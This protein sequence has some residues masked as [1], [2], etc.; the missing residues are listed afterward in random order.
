M[1]SR[2]TA[3][4]IESDPFERERIAGWLVDE[5]IDVL[6]CPGPTG[7]DYSCLG[8]RG[9]PCPLAI[10]CDVVILDMHLESDS[11]LRGTP[12]WELLLYYL[13]LGKRVVA[14]AGQEDTL[15]P[16]PDEDVSVVSRPAEREM[17]LRAVHEMLMHAQIKVG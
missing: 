15:L 14:L 1:T 9:R 6:E 17:L 7:P 2:S 3:L 16:V 10:P 5:G 13:R 11:V 4:I 12:A 8:G